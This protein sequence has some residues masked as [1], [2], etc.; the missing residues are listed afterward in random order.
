MTE[1]PCSFNRF[2]VILTGWMERLTD[3]KLDAS[4]TNTDLFSR[5]G[6][7]VKG[8]F[9]HQV[10]I[11]VDEKRTELDMPRQHIRTQQIDI[12]KLA[13]LLPVDFTV[14]ITHRLSKP[15]TDPDP[16]VVGEKHHQQRDAHMLGDDCQGRLVLRACQKVAEYDD[17]Q[18]APHDGNDNRRG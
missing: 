11:D 15:G 13:E 4:R 12:C 10:K 18:H 7:L 16:D 3:W 14:W 9:G 6:L 5:A 8:M 17:D 2:A 1:I